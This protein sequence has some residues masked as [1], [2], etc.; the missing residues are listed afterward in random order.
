MAV[1][2]SL[3]KAL[4]RGLTPFHLI[5]TEPAKQSGKDLKERGGKL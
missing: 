1:S 2:Q 3:Q 5:L 4:Q